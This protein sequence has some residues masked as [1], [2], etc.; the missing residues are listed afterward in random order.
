M[1]ASGG[2]HRRSANS[3]STDSTSPALDGRVDACSTCYA[4]TGL[5][6]PLRRR[7][8]SLG[9][10]LEP[11]F[12]FDSRAIT[13]F[14]H[15]IARVKQQSRVLVCIAPVEFWAPV[16]AFAAKIGRASCRGGVSVRQG[17]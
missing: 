12:E 11:R 7:A 9:L 2:P 6:V 17:T 13:P 1:S 14:A 4:G 15:R 8:C 5:A 3:Q 10:T 16:N